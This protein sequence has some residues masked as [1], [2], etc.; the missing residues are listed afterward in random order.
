MGQHVHVGVHRRDRVG[1]RRGVGEHPEALLVRLVDDHV[2]GVGLGPAGSGDQDGLDRV[3]AVLL[4]LADGGA[5]HVVRDGGQGLDRTIRRPGRVGAAGVGVLAGRLRIGRL[6]EALGEGH[7][8]GRIE[9]RALD[10]AGVQPPLQLQDLGVVAHREH[11]REARVQEAL[12]IGG[13]RV[14]QPGVGIADEQVPVGVDEAGH[15]GHA[16]GVDLRARRALGRLA[17]ADRD[18]PPVLGHH[19]AMLDDLPGP[20]DDAGVADDQ[21]LRQGAAGAGHAERNSRAA[22]QDRLLQRH[23]PSP[24]FCLA[25]FDGFDAAPSIPHG[26]GGRRTLA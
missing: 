11:G 12:H 19:R 14:F 3:I 4:G 10:L 18:D 15:H 16:V 24:G 26:S 20:V 25:G 7:D 5:G 9:S 8:Q 13:R 23:R 1:H 2:Q 6:R 21:V 17:A 22:R